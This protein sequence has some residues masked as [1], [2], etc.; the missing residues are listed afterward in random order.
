MLQ[1]ERLL[2]AVGLGT[3]SIDGAALERAL[4]EHYP[5]DRFFIRPI[6]E[7]NYPRR[8][9]IAQTAR[10]AFRNIQV[11]QRDKHLRD[12][13][14]LFGVTSGE[15]RTDAGDSIRPA[16]W[17]IVRWTVRNGPPSGYLA[18]NQ[19]DICWQVQ[20]HYVGLTSTPE[21][22]NMLIWQIQDQLKTALPSK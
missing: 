11:L 20:G 10:R 14:V 13:Y 18:L 21:S 12:A 22:I 5:L 3:K 8:E 9:E 16:R 6:A 2:F 1:E 4:L 17:D 15:V 7:D 19:S